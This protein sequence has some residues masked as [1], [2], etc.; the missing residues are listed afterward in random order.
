LIG[1]AITYPQC[2]FGLYHDLNLIY[3]FEPGKIFKPEMT[4]CGSRDFSVS[5]PCF[6]QNPCSGDQTN[7]VKAC[8]GLN[9]NAFAGRKPC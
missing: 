9:F 2:C 6:Q 8:A 4:I 7:R 5:P 1:F 3:F